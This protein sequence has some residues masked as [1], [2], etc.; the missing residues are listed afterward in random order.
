MNENEEIKNG[1]N[2]EGS[3]TKGKKIA[4]EIWEWVYTLAIAV[5]AAMLIKG[6][7][8]DIVKVDGPSMTPTLMDNDR[9]IVTKLG[10][11]PQQGDIIILDSAYAKRKA[12]L[13]DVAE[14]KGKEKLNFF[15]KQA[16]LKEVPEELEKNY[17][18][19]DSFKKKYY[20]KRI[21]AMPG[22]TVDI[23]D[24]KVYVDGEILEEEYY[25]GSTGITDTSVE[26]P[27]TVEDDCVF[28]MGDH[29]SNSTDSRSKSLGQVPFKAILGKSQLRIWP[30]DDIGVT[31]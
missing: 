16:A 2:E 28:V 4:K 6:F 22:Q 15:E 3:G 1:L 20:V 11:K 25:K 18:D 5:I 12:Y 24:G 13:E 31:R 21:I 17:Y 23:V 14:V 19:T 10:Y 27:V 7:V 9:L 30:L 26:Y 8:F 29:R